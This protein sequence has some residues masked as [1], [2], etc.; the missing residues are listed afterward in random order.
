MQGKFGWRGIRMCICMGMRIPYPE[1]SN[2]CLMANEVNWMKQRQLN[3]ER[4]KKALL[5]REIFKEE[6]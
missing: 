6:T 2:F 5:E 4:S 1:G 3:V